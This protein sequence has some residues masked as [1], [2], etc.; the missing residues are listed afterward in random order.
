MGRKKKDSHRPVLPW[1]YYCDREF[2]EE[3][4][5]LRHQKERHFTCKICHKRSS[6]ATSLVGHTWHVHQ[7]TMSRI[8]NAIPGR[9]LPPKSG[10]YDIIGSQGIPT[11]MD[12]PGLRKAAALAEEEREAK[13]KAE[14]LEKAA[15]RAEAEAKATEA[16][17]LRR[18]AAEAAAEEEAKSTAKRMA[19]W[20]ATGAGFSLGKDER[21]AKKHKGR[22]SAAR[23]AF[24]GD[25]DA[26]K[27]EEKAS[28][29][30]RGG[31]ASSTLDDVPEADI[32]AALQREM[33]AEQKAEAE[34]ED[35]AMAAAVAD[36]V[37]KEEDEATA[38][39]KKVAQAAAA[40]A[41]N[42]RHSGTVKMFNAKG[43]GFVSYETPDEKV[44][45]K[46]VQHDVYVHRSG[47]VTHGVADCETGQAVSFLISVQE[48]GRKIAVD[49]RDSR[50]KPVDDAVK[51]RQEE[52]DKHASTD[53]V[54]IEYGSDTFTGRKEDNEDRFMSAAGGADGES[55]ELDFGK[56]FG[57]YD[58]HNGAE[59]S[60]YVTANL[61]SNALKRW[62]KCGRPTR[63]D[64]KQDKLVQCL[65]EAF[66]QTDA[67]FLAKKGNVAGSTA[68]AV[69]LHGRDPPPRPQSKLGGAM[70]TP[71]SQP[72]T[73]PLT[74]L[75]CN[76]GDSRAVLCRGGRALALS[77][78]HKPNRRDEK[79]RVERAG[80]CCVQMK[81]IWRVCTGSAGSNT[82]LGTRDSN[83]Y[84]AVSRAFGDPQLKSGS[85]PLVSSTPEIKAET[86]QAEDMFF[87][88]A[89]DGV[90]DVMTDQEAIDIAAKRLVDISCA[91]SPKAAAAA[92]V[93][94]AYRRNSGDNLT[95]TVVQ[96][97]WQTMTRM[98]KYLANY[99]WEKEQE[100]AK[101]KKALEEDEGFDMFA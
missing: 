42:T 6:T 41:A 99:E 77:E 49:V 44:K 30:G 40:Q 100:A 18:V 29:N 33:E 61:H 66:E 52:R 8:P 76:L 96:F 48:D 91:G 22:D 51:R 3:G 38:T 93:K 90:W 95:A 4:V 92:V 45:G 69:L 26:D 34:A 47:L 20:S 39:A 70:F 89:C 1:C 56:W 10:G 72:K 57:V 50:G 25:E 98:K 28:D 9:D 73:T 75:T 55:V 74:L 80:G 32:D 87:L 43:F 64:G 7:E 63:V 19:E 85:P 82:T 5:L 31:W 88:L 23:A 68:I 94:E 27:D 62:E 101:K 54:P 67:E 65:T 37:K 58:G 36:A 12:P 84:L 46:M 16:L 71:A 53:R 59:M 11:G 60:E 83:L 15:R 17:R 13:E 86:V 97:G 24:S 14:R 2:K 35:A 81:G 21:S 79:A 78:D